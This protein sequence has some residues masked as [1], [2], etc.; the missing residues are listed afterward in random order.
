MTIV[1]AALC[2][3][4]IGALGPEILRRVPEPPV[5]DDDKLPYAVLA[6]FR[7]LRLGL[8][9]AAATMAAVVAWRI[10]EPE[11]LP[12]WVVVAGVGALLSFVD[13][14][15]RLLPFLI[16]APLYVVTIA[17]VGLGALLLDDRDVLVH[18]LVAN[19]VVYGVF[20]L[21]HWAGNRFAGGA[22][23]YGDVRLSGVL[24][25]ALGA[26]GTDEVL[27]GMYAGFILGAVL[28]VV[29][30]RLRIVDPQGFAFGPYMVAGAVLGAA[31]G[32]AI[33]R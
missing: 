16:V 28:G 4:L 31:F 30:S 20:R 23:G 22:F 18:A 13:W 14:H 3:A 10:D 15:T 8:A 29:L 33:Y 17:L 32:P 19:V 24:A 11:L 2:A 6:E 26:L 21:L 25:P 12:V 5:P 27:V 9:A 7:L 1:V